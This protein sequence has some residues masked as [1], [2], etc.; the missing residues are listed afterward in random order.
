M[1]AP[2]RW[3]DVSDLVSPEDFYRPDHGALFELLKKMLSGEDKDT[4]ELMTVVDR[5]RREGR[6]E[7][8]GGVAYIADLPNEVPSDAN[9]A[10]YALW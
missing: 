5:V 2:A 6:A 1:I 8:Y 10:H 9:L 7:R 4:V 3:S